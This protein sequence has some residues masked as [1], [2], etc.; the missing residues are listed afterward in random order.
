[1]SNITPE[2]RH[3]VKVIQT[4]D[5]QEQVMRHT[6][7]VSTYNGLKIREYD[8]PHVHLVLTNKL[9]TSVLQRGSF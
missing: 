3:S 4:D 2:H 7:K 9:F 5:K 8:A 1:M 6:L